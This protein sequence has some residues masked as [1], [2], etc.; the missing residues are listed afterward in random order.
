MPNPKGGHDVKRL[1]AVCLAAGV[2][3]SAAV[4]VASADSP[5][6][7]AGQPNCKGQLT[8]AGAQAFGGLGSIVSG[9]AHFFN[10]QGTSLGQTG[11]PALKANCPT[12]PPPP[13]A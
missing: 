6:P 12:P 9:Y 11:I 4:P 8:A 7:V 10:S 1:L 13:P 3:G 5:G 2:V